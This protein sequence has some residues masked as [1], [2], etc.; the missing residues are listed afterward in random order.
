MAKKRAKNALAPSLFPEQSTGL[1]NLNLDE[2]SLPKDPK[3]KVMHFIEELQRATSLQARKQVKAHVQSLY[4]TSMSNLTEILKEL[5]IEC[6]D[7]M[8]DDSAFTLSRPIA[9]DHGLVI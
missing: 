5:C 4:S 7:Q 9:H 1:I 2:S 6:I 8:I 3:A